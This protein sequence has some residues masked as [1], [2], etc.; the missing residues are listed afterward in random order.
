MTDSK[1]ALTG[2]RI[3][4]LTSVLFGP[5]GTQQLG[6]WGADVIKVETLDGDL[7]R[8]TGTARTRGMSGQFMAVNRNKRSIALDLKHSSAE[9]VVTALL[10]SADALVSNVRP[11]ALA[12]LGLGYDR[13]HAIKPDL[14]YVEATG[15]DQ[16]GPWAD[17]PAFDDIV[18]AASGFAVTLTDDNTPEL[19][20]S[21]LADKICGLALTSAVTAALLHRERTGQGQRIEVPMLETLAAFNAVEALGGYAFEPPEGDAGYARVRE[22]RAAQTRDG[23]IA[24]LPY[25]EKQWCDFLTAVDRADWIET[26]GVRDPVTR[27]ANIDR[28]YEGMRSVIRERSTADW[29]QLLSAIDIP[30]ARFSRVEE[31]QRHPHLRESGLFVHSEH[32]SEG[33]IVQA[34][35]TTRFNKSPA[36]IRRPAP[37]LGEHTVEILE[38]LGLDDRQIDA[39]LKSNAVAGERG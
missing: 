17:R 24:L 31:L 30:H 7:W 10:K 3:I 2:Y 1:G 27:A 4:D 37:R 36:A 12:R 22:R 20:P 21:L 15:F 35:P 26:F 5:M 25:S 28:L 9:V 29:E 11:A 38:E 8:Y 32:P 19:P 18:Q 34:R 23:W 16:T 6:D 39:L 13:C 14:V 33:T